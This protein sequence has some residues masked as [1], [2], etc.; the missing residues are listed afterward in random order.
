MSLWKVNAYGFQ[1]QSQ[2]HDIIRAKNADNPERESNILILL[3]EIGITETKDVPL[4][5]S[6]GMQLGALAQYLR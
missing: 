6:E 3:R 1:P 4:R 5:R 2:E